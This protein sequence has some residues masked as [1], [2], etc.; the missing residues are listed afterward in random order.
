MNDQS[1]LS[2]VRAISEA[3]SEAS[4]TLE[5]EL[6]DHLQINSDVYNFIGLALEAVP[7]A[8]LRDVTQAR[9]V[10]SCLLVRIANDLRCIGV[11]S[12]RGYADQ[13]CA[14]AASLYEAAFAAL[15]INDNETLAQE[16]IDHPDPNRLFKSVRELT[17]MGMRALGIPNAEHQA[18]RW[19][20][21]YS[22]L[23]MPKHINPLIQTR[24]GFRI[25]D[26]RVWIGTG[27]DTTDESVRL[28]WFALEHSAAF[29][30]TAAGFF[31]QKYAREN[32]ELVMQNRGL[33]EAIGKLRDAAVARGWDKNPFPDY[34]K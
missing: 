23:C 9:K 12:I 8:R 15:A 31:G 32:R 4:R 5:P 13:A 21:T 1:S 34:W 20:I 22:Q 25:E 30:L 18:K 19:Y 10:T 26:Y 7:D 14:L 2:L 29:A 16:W 6:K 17:L 24:R 11:L 27:P 3:E 33:H 28:T